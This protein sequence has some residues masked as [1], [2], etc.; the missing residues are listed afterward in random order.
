MKEFLLRSCALVA[1]LLGG[2]IG[3]MLVLPL[4]LIVYEFI[5]WP[6]TL[7]FGA[8]LAAICA[9]WVG[10]FLAPD[11]TRS[12]LLPVVAV[13]EVTA[14][15]VA[16]CLVAVG[17]LVRPRFPAVGAMLGPPAFLLGLC[18]VVIA[19]SASW[20]AWRFRGPG[21]RSGRDALI[22]LVLL[23]SGVLILVATLYVAGLLGL[24]QG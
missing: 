16:L 6:L 9:S 22:T 5:L 23:G 1:A 18:M 2:T 4:G 3:G 12:R 24:V 15:V 21:R 11:A 8:L 19:L 17:V 10:T 20:A 7:G 14:A 13:S